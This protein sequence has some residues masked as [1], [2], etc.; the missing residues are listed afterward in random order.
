M[1]RQS[2]FDV[3]NKVNV[4][5]PVAVRDEV[6]RLLTARYTA[7]D[8]APLV[9]AFDVYVRIY[10]GTLPGYHGCDTWYHDA[11][12]PLDCALAMARLI[13]GHERTAARRERLGARRAQLG[14]ICALF[15]DVGYI[16]RLDETQYRNGAQLTLVHVE[17]SG[18]FLEEFLRAVGYRRAAPMVRKMVHFTGYEMPLD[19]VQ[20][21]DPRDRRLGFLLATADLLAQMSDRAYLEK[22]RTFLYREF[23]ACG[24]A[25]DGIP[26]GPKPI[27]G[28]PDDMIRKTPEFVQ[29]MFDE[30]LDGYFEGAHRCL[31]SHF[32][33]ANPYVAEVRK[34]VDYARCVID[35]GDMGLLRRTPECI[36]AHVL[37]R[38]LGLSLAEAHPRAEPAELAELTPALAR[39][40]RSSFLP[41]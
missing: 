11:Q 34:H 37:R 41:L 5:D 15:H 25:G 31:E 18:A 9:R 36:N 3:T 14:V 4:A 35:R 33:G 7:I 23:E 8:L 19:Q 30:R 38:E 16:R 26:N 28:S 17:R 40:A 22:C 6:R 32:G 21:S 24:L 29:R 2:H 13:D 12:H 10:S 39:L 27:Y 20:V 1:V